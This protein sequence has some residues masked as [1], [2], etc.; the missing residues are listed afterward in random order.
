MAADGLF[1]RGVARL[2]PR[3]RTPSLA[4]GLQA[5]WSIALAL[6]GTYAA[7]VDTVVFADWIFFGLTVGSV[8]VFRRRFP[9]ASR[10]PGGFRSPLHPVLPIVF[11]IVSAGVVASVVASNPVRS[12]VGAG[13]LLAGVPAFLYWRR[14][15]PS[16]ASE[17][18]GRGERA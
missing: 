11:A 12:V 10:A 6:T 5:A 17:A 7:L 18:N 1:F 3:F 2:H 14:R 16:P 4:I 15:A 8:L 13:L 9:L